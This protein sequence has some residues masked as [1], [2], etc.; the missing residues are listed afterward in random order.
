MP[1]Y[2]NS[3]GEIIEERTH[4]GREDAKKTAAPTVKQEGSLPPVPSDGPAPSTAEFSYDAPTRRVGEA[5]SSGDDPHTRLVGSRRSSSDKERMAKKA[6]KT[7]AMDDP[8]VGWL[9]VVDGPGK[10]RS[11]QLGYGANSI[12]RAREHRVPL[13]H[14]D[15]QIS[16]EVH[17]VVTYD[18]RGRKFYVQHGEGRN[19]TYLNDVPVLQP[20]EL[21]SCAHI[22]IGNTTLRFIPMCGEI[23]DWQDTE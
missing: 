19:L 4:A 8:V 1:V 11:F 20:T 6:K 16:R 5:R 21:N 14:G 7:D 15:D 9:V 10:G 12:G 22:V 17:A 18:P 3:E 2:R 13:D 23:F